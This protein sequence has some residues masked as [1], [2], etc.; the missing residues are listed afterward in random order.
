MEVL[1]TFP[2]GN[3]RPLRTRDIAASGQG[4]RRCVSFSCEGPFSVERYVCLPWWGER[5]PSCEC[6]VHSRRDAAR[7]K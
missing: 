5:A 4:V 7:V 3:E 2:R 6:S 1:P